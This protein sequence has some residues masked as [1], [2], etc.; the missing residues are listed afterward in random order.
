[1]AR[2]RA[3]I[4]RTEVA[5]PSPPVGLILDQ[6]RY[7]ATLNGQDLELTAVEFNLLKFLSSKTGQVCTRQQLMDSIYPDERIVADRTIDSHIKKL[8][9]KIALSGAKSEFIH[10]LYG[11]GYKFEPR[12]G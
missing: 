3:V 2:V 9:R 7:Q 1:I 12:E 11:V 6:S 10:S 4:R 8:R 5:S